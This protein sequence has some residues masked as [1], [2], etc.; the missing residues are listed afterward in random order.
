[1]SFSRYQAIKPC[2]ISQLH[3]ARW[4]ESKWVW[5]ASCSHHP[6]THTYW[7]F[8]RWATLSSPPHPTCHGCLARRGICSSAVQKKAHSSCT[9]NCGRGTAA[10][11]WHVWSDEDAPAPTSHLKRHVEVLLL[12]HQAV[13]GIVGFQPALKPGDERDSLKELLAAKQL[14]AT[15]SNNPPSQLFRSNTITPY[16]FDGYIKLQ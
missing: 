10:L 7:Y 1:M 9:E 3:S 16:K 14:A 8:I 5:Q 2:Q 6:R 15:A 11:F 12:S 13:S 4:S